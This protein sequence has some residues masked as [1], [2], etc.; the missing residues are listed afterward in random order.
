MRPNVEV[1]FNQSSPFLQAMTLY[2]L[3]FLFTA[4]SWLF[5]PD[6]L[7]KTAGILLV[8]AFLLHTRLVL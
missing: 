2:V 8:V 4:L 3:V 6:T 5:W 1:L 7:S